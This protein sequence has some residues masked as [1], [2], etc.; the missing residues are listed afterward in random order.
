MDS[1]RGLHPLIFSLLKFVVRSDYRD[2]GK[3]EAKVWSRPDI[4][5]R[6]SDAEVKTKEGLQ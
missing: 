2:Q 1:T 5:S 4:K 3:T 6:G